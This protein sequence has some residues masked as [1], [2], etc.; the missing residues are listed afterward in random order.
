MVQ[1]S[2]LMRVFFCRRYFVGSGA[3]RGHVSESS[4]YF[5]SS[6]SVRSEKARCVMICAFLELCLSELAGC[7][8]VFK[9]AP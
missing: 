9:C 4:S 7:L 6:F 2:G 8:D 1:M 5:E 3:H